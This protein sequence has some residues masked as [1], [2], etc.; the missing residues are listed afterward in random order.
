MQLSGERSEQFWQALELDV[1]G[2]VNRA[3]HGA[4]S[5]R[6][7]TI[8]YLQDLEAIAWKECQD[9]NVIQIIQSSRSLLGDQTEA[10]QRPKR[11]IEF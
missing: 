4:Q 5:L 3:L 8:E 10:T 11:P 7:Q 2:R 6:N 9:R 1:A